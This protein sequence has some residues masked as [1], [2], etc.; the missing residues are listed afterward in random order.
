VGEDAFLVSSISFCP[1]PKIVAGE[2]FVFLLN[3]DRNNFIFEMPFSYRMNGRDFDWDRE[4]FVECAEFAGLGE[5]LVCDWA[6]FDW[7][8]EEFPDC[9]QFPARGEEFVSD[10]T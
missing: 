8:G 9:A 7:I 6:D 4:D 5:D 3:I 2:G 10:L 1:S